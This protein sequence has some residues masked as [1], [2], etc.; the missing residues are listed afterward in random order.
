M[1][2]E[3][4][5]GVGRAPAPA[6]LAAPTPLAA[7]ARGQFRFA[8]MVAVGMLLA[9]LVVAWVYDLPVREPDSV[10]G[11]TWLRLPLIL[12][13]AFLL[14]VL[15]RA[16][17]RAWRRRG[18]QHLPGT[19]REVVRD[20]WG[21]PHLTFALVGLGAWYVT[22]A[23]FR[24]LKSFVP[25]VN[26]HLW[27]DTLEDIDRVL[28]LGHNPVAA[29]HALFGTGLAAEFFSFLYIADRKSV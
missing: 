9:T 11:P 6:P 17:A 26:L 27:D 16:T 5:T 29:T 10:A 18:L 12:L 24:N 4:G 3:V 23:S 13:A 20:R 21:L 1:R 2:N 15:P 7:P 19:V 25:F 8:V 14:D 22:Y 28:F